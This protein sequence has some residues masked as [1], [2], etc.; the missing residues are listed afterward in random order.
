MP[1]LF[2]NSNLGT[3]SGILDLLRNRGRGRHPE[4]V[5]APEGSQELTTNQLDHPHTI[6]AGDPNLTSGKQGTLDGKK[7]R[8]SLNNFISKINDPNINGFWQ[9]N[10]FVVEIYPRET[11]SETVRKSVVDT[12]FLC[13]SAALPGVQII[14]SDHR[15]QNMGT[16]DR[17][18]FGVQVTDIPLTFFIDQRGVILN[19]FRTWTNDI[20]NYKYNAGKGGE[21]SKIGGRQLFEIAYRDSY[22][23]DID[24]YCMDQKQENILRYHLY[25]AFPMQVGDVT[26]AWAETDSFGLLAV[27]FTFRTYDVEVMDPKMV[28]VVTPDKNI[29]TSDLAI[30]TGLATTTGGSAVAGIGGRPIKLPG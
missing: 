30:K 29:T 11:C 15:R 22:L 25:E 13:S 10:R 17:R 6:K 4:H 5:F 1:S 23:C 2:K 16:F 27:Q 21:H 28:D 8:F 14:T 9:P 20:I 12:K 19:L 26:T 24:I 3:A 18:P 7:A